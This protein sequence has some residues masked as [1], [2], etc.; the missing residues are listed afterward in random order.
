MHDRLINAKMETKRVIELR[1]V[2]IYQGE[3]SRKANAENNL[4]LSNVNLTVDEGEFV[5]LI[6][7]VG[8]GKSTLLKLLSKVT[9]PTIG[10]IRARGRIARLLEVA[11]GHHDNHRLAELVS[12]ER[13]EDMFGASF[14]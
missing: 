7:R 14:G 2:S 10:T 5:Y 4:V 12:D 9:A 6:G 1:N 3:V 13:V 8:T 11:V